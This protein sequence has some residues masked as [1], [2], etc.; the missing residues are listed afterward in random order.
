MKPLIIL[1]FLKNRSNY[2]YYNWIVLN[3]YSLICNLNA[4][5]S[6]ISKLLNADAVGVLFYFLLHFLQSSNVGLGKERRWLV[7]DGGQ[8]K[9]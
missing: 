7:I 8:W 1:F 5:Y 2:N 4:L 3:L 6:Y 9:Q